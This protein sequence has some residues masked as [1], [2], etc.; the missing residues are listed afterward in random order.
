MVAAQV[1]LSLSHWYIV[2][3]ILNDLVLHLKI[4]KYKQ[5]LLNI[6]MGWRCICNFWYKI[7]L[8]NLISFNLNIQTVFFKHV[9]YSVCYV[10]IYDDSRSSHGFSWY[11][12]IDVHR[13]TTPNPPVHKV[14]DLSLLNDDCDNWPLNYRTLCLQ[15]EGYKALSAALH[16]KKLHF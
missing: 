15:L 16:D 4:S 13:A 7:S 12:D 8:I 11:V 3:Y 1:L 2:L 10:F 6:V 14:R 9:G 5:L